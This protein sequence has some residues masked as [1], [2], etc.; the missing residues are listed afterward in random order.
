MSILLID[1]ARQNQQMR[2]ERLKK[3]M[4]E[5]FDG[6]QASLARAIGKGQTQ[7]SH[8]FTGVRPIGEKVARDIE[9]ALM[10]PRGWLDNE[11]ETQGN[12]SPAPEIKGAVPLLSSVQAGAYKEHTDNFHA[13][14]GGMEL[15][16]TSV[17]VRA[18]TFALRVSG[19]SME[20]EFTDG[21]I[22]IVEPELDAQ[23]GDYVIAKNG[24]EETTFKQLIKDGAD[25]Y[26]KPL[27]A[28]YPIKPLGDSQIIGV[29]RAVERRFR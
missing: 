2:V 20:P 19:D 17:P 10:L 6:S 12:T 16:A 23:P 5:R 13:G 7:V 14:D 28:R 29:V 15:I 22:L 27:N 8:W 25:W 24:S 9:V 21:M 11:H 3:L 26:L 1:K 4:L 18:H